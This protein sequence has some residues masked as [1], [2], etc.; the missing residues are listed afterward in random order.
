M[1]W[2]DLQPS[3]I[4]PLVLPESSRD[5]PVPTEY[6]LDTVE[7]ITGARYDCRCVLKMMMKSSRTFQVH[8]SGNETN[9]AYNIVT[10]CLEPMTYAEVL[11]QYLS[12]DP[13]VPPEVMEAV[14]APN[15]PFVDFSTRLVLITFLSY[16]FLYSNEYKKVVVATGASWIQHEETCR[17]CTKSGDMVLCDTCEAAFHLAC[18]NL[19]KKPDE[20][21]CE[22]CEKHKVRYCLPFDEFPSKQPL[23][24]EPVGRDRHGRFYWFVARR[25]FVHNMDDSD[26]RYYSTAPQFYQLVNAMDPTFYEYHLCD[27]FYERLREILEQAALPRIHFTIYCYECRHLSVGLIFLRNVSESDLLQL[28]NRGMEAITRPDPSSLFRMGC[29]SNDASFR[30]KNSLMRIVFSPSALRS[31][32]LYFSKYSNQ[33]VEHKYGEHPLT[34]KK[35]IDKKKYL[36]SK[37]SLMDEGE[38]WSIAKGH[39]LYGSEKLQTLYV[40]WTIGKLLRKIPVELMQRKWPEALPTFRKDL[41]HPSATWKTLRD[42]LLRL[43]CGMRR[44]LFLPQWWN[45]LGHTRLTRTTVEDRERWV[46]ESARKKKEERVRTMTTVH[47]VPHNFLSFKEKYRVY[48][49]GELGGWLWISRTLVRDIRES[50]SFPLMH[51]SGTVEVIPFTYLHNALTALSAISYLCRPYLAQSSGT[52]GVVKACDPSRTV[53]HRKGVLGEDLPWPLP[54]VNS[55]VS[56]GSKRTSIFVL[57][58]VTLRKLAKTGGRKAVYLPSFST[59]AKGNLQYWN[60]PTLRPCFDLCWRWLTVNCSSL[61]AVALQLRILW[62]SVRWQD[63]NPEDDD[64]DRRVVNH[65]PDRDERRWIS[66][67]KEYAPPCIYER[68]F[69]FE[70]VVIFLLVHLPQ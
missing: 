5:I 29:P 41:D 33:F 32:L 64:P 25:I 46:K 2:V 15:Y 42:L 36:C 27:V 45:S 38:W 59:T 61:Q 31:S 6:L 3:E 16:R 23:R 63:L 28:R 55:F 24:M 7:V 66:L 12:C 56:R 62:A 39:N 50:P 19:E 43:E 69:P 70:L 44:T 18:A 26:L 17:S 13:N 54:D 35:M 49:R 1:P 60:Y 48:G 37:F 4:P 21:V 34:K 67:H 30:S 11:R 14:N 22:L 10:A 65:F 40:A 8:F 9:N 57:P 53:V 51:Q 68:Y 47:P 52:S 58:Q 20:W